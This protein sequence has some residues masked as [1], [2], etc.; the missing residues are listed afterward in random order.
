M[1]HRLTSDVDGEKFSPMENLRAEVKVVFTAV[2]PLVYVLC[3]RKEEGGAPA[4]RRLDLLYLLLGGRLKYEAEGED[5]EE[6]IY[7][8][9]H[10]EAMAL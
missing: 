10:S 6:G 8:A 2:G 4:H 7:G 3:S 1:R 5:A 9:N